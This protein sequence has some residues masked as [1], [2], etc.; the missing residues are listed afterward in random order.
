M[1][2]KVPGRLRLTL[3]DGLVVR[4]TGMKRGALTVHARPNSQRVAIGRVN[5]GPGGTA[6]ARVR[7]TRSA[8]RSLARRKSVRLK[9][10]AG[11]LSRTI[12]VKR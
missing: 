11:P 7:F 2:I 10:K 1:S 3:R 4:L 6:T 5:V 8:R 12:T 9:V